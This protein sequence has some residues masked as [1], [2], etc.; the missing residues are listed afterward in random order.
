VLGAVV[1]RSSHFGCTRS[2]T[3]TM[4]TRPGCVTLE[5]ADA[6][7]RRAKGHASRDRWN[8]FDLIRHKSYQIRDAAARGTALATPPSR[9]SL[10]SPCVSKVRIGITVSIPQ[11]H[12]PSCW[13]PI[14]PISNSPSSHLRMTR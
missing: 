9:R 1:G 14:E 3:R 10:P 2:K 4:L 5:E 11:A 12:P 13:M 7:F 6:L 8:C